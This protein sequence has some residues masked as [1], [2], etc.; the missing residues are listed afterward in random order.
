MRLTQHASNNAVLAAPPGSTIEECRPAAI[1][2]IA[3]SDGTSA[4]ATYWLPSAREREL[5]AAGALVRVEV[6]GQTM[7]PMIVTAEGERTEGGRGC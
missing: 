7:A 6:L 2:R 5:I 4:V 3:Y 1:T